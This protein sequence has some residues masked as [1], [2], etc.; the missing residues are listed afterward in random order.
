M[1][2]V[3]PTLTLIVGIIIGFI[4]GVHYLKRKMTNMT[5]DENQM[6]QMAKQMGMNLN[7]KQINQMN[8]MMRNRNQ[9]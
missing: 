4:V 2:I 8:R 1:D 3:I 6:K 9:K 7:Q 5:M